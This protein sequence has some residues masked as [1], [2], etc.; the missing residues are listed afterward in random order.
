MQYNYISE[1]PLLIFI[2]TI[3]IFYLIHKNR[4]SVSLGVYLGRR[5][6]KKYQGRAKVWNY[7]IF[8]FNCLTTHIPCLTVRHTSQAG[9]FISKQT[10]NKKLAIRKYAVVNQHSVVVGV[11]IN[12]SKIRQG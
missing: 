2:N 3:Y 8:Q 11:L 1:I 6:L 7:C 9:C 4:E 10:N 5:P 12:G